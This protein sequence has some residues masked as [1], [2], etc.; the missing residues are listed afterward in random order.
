M[1]QK[2]QKRTQRSRRKSPVEFRSE[3]LGHDGAS[4]QLRLPIAEILSGV[5]D[6]V[7]AVAAEAGL[8]VMKTLIEEE[9]EK[10]AGPRYRHRPER[11]ASRW[12][13]AEGS[14]VFAGRRVPLERP[15][16]RSRD[17]REVPL[18][19]YELFRSDGRL[20]R[21]VTPRVLAGVAMRDYEGTLD[22]VCDGY[23][24]QKS[25]VSRH[26]KA[27]SAARL[28]EFLA[29]PLGGLDLVALMIDGI[30]FHDFLLVVALGLDSQGK[31]H[32]LGLW[33]G[34][35]ENAAVC[36]DLLANLVER[37]LA[38]DRKYLVVID[39]SKALA[40]AVRA[41][42]GDQ[43]VIQRCQV[44]KERNVLEQLPPE[45]HGRMRQRL[46]AAWNLKNYAEAEAALQKVVL[47]LEAL[48]PAAANSL[49]EGLAETLTVHR[50][51]V[52]EKL[53][54]TLRSTNPIE[55]CFSATRKHCR[56]VKRWRS[57]EMAQRWVGTML[58]EVER[59]F[60]RVRGH[61]E[62]PLLVAA[63]RPREAAESSAA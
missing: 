10:H 46:R 55:S 32:V 34:A 53:R 21:A 20:Q 18:E 7:E 60:R 51:G 8:L 3:V 38:T 1:S 47:D 15:R 27:V 22:A 56:N 48:S 16:L 50:L 13:Q 11:T 61:R 49:R 9:V 30:E 54:R 45:H 40:K 58:L 35:T 26:W 19:R 57:Q 33:P 44:H 36:K 14:V 37:G 5:Q 42:F 63:L 59:G 25:S 39:G 62:M 2:Y 52:P 12:G 31:K 29:R 6:A 28:Q 17:G 41:T 43:A 24:V 4:V 23:G